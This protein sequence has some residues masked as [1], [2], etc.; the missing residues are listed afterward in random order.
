MA[1]GKWI[2]VK[3][4]VVN[5]NRRE[6]RSAMLEEYGESLTRMYS[7]DDDIFEVMY[8]KNVTATINSFVDGPIE[9]KF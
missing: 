2:R 9:L 1:H 7:L 4:E 8:L 3:A 6:A 5:D